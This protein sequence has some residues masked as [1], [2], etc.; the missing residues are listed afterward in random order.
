MYD[1]E[2]QLI[3][4]LITGDLGATEAFIGHFNPLIRRWIRSNSWLRPVDDIAQQVWYHLLEDHWKRLLSWDGLYADSSNPRSLEA[5]LKK[6][7][8]NKARDLERAKNRD[9]PAAGDPFPIIIDDGPVGA[10]PKTLAERERL[11]AVFEH[12]FRRLQDRDRLNLIM[13]QEGHSDAEIGERLGM[14]ANNASQRRFQ[15]LP[16]LRLCLEEHL[17]EYVCDE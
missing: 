15:A 8:V 6:V 2:R 11:I 14:T 17:P 9:L 4:G 13:W 5:F 12:C 1:P 7:T 3:R 16:R 10:D